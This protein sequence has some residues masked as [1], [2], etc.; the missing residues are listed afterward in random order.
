[1]LGQFH[2]LSPSD[3]GLGTYG[4]PSGFYD[5]QIRTFATISDAQAKVRDVTTQKEVGPI[6]HYDDMVAYFQHSQP[7]DRTSLVH[8]DFKI[9]NVVFH[10][11]EP[12]IIGILE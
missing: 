9:D 7:P 12:R 1:M 8:G 6:P 3:V 11:T 5:R 10:K 2:R 4:K